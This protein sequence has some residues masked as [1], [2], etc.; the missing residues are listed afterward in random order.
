MCLSL[1]FLFSLILYNPSF[2]IS[3]FE[4]LNCK[5]KPIQLWI[6]CCGSLNEKRLTFSISKISF[7]LFSPNFVMCAIHKDLN[8]FK[9]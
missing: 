5:Q 7:S 6:D 4:V 1:L 9:L 3:A 2:V 8:K